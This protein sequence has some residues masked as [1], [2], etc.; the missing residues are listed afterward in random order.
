MKTDSL[1]RVLVHDLKTPTATVLPTLG[2]LLPATTI[3]M[4]GG[5]LAAAGVRA[6]AFSTGLPPTVLKVALGVVLAI[7]GLIAAL[8]LS[9][10]ASGRRYPARL[11]LIAPLAT[12]LIAAADLMLF[13]STGWQARLWGKNIW[14]CLAAIPLLAGLPLA[15]AMLAL[16]HGATE[17]AM[18]TGAFAGLGAAGLA[19]V[20][21]GLFCTEDTVMFV[22]VWYVLAACI[23]S[24]VGAMIGRIALR[25]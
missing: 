1:I 17:H 13:G 4:T 14:A 21:Y 19:I 10:P 9:R 8:K 25:W 11:L 15:A 12:V 22:G 7:T 16:R 18:I 24:L 3:V 20:A 5:F 23:A 2:R 6:D